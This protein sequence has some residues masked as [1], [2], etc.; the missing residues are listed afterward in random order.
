[1]ADL[2]GL[3]GAVTFYRTVEAAGLQPLVGATLTMGEAGAAVV[4]AKSLTGYRQLCRLLSAHHLDAG[5]TMYACANADMSNELIFLSRSPRLLGRLKRCLGKENLFRLPGAPAVPTLWDAGSD[6]DDIAPA[7]VP[8]AWLLHEEDREPFQWLRELRRRSGQDHGQAATWPGAV[9]PEVGEWAQHHPGAAAFSASLCERISFRFRFGEPL[10]PRVTLPPETSSSAY[11]RD[12]CEKQLQQIYRGRERQRAARRLNHELAVIQE[13]GFSD[14]FLCVHEIIAFAGQKNIPVGVRGS[15]ASSI[16]SHLLGFTH[17]CPLEHD[18]LFERFMNPG[19]RDCP[20]IDI[21]IADNRRDEVIDFCY[22]R[23]GK[24]RVAMIATVLTYRRRSAIRDAGRLLNISMERM[25]RFIREGE[26]VPGQARL[27]RIAEKLTGLPRH[28]GMHCGGLVI[29]PCPLTDVTP[30]MRSAKGV[31]I[32]QYEKDQAETIGLIKMDLLGNSAL[33]VISEAAGSL[34]ERGISFAEP[35]PA[36]DY[37]VNRLFAKGDTLGVY[38]CESPGMRQLCRALK[39]ETPKEASIA[40][41]LIRPGPAAAGMKDTFVRRRRGREPVTYL[42]P[43][44]ADFLAPTYGV[45]LYQ[46]D[47]MKVAVH[48]AGYSLADADS[49]RRAVSRKKGVR[50]MTAEQNRFVF[51]KAA[52]A[53]VSEDVSRKLW[54]QVSHFASYSYCKAHATVYG[55]LAWLTARLKAHYPREFYAAVLNCHKSMYPR[56]VFVWDAIRHGIPVLPVD[57]CAS[58]LTWTPCLKGIRA[59]LTLVKGLRRSICERLI[60]ARREAPFSGLDDLRRRVPF[61][62][63]ELQSLI[64]LGACR[65]WGTRKHLLSRLLEIEGGDRQRLLFDQVPCSLSSLLEAELALTGIPLSAHPAFFWEGQGCRAVEMPRFLNQSVWMTG[66]LDAFRRVRTEAQ[67]GRPSREMSFLTL[68]D[69]SGMF[70]V[71]L[72]PEQEARYAGKI[73]HGGPYRVWGRVRRRW[74]SLC[75]EAETIENA[76]DPASWR[77]AA[78]S[79]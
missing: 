15:A 64:F 6:V 38:Q 3:Y 68:E 26:P 39:P 55:R 77:T 33:S 44:M 14:Y 51:Q 79:A 66:I 30:L 61:R 63:G 23:W 54:E 7:P 5:D 16:V 70:E 32:S 28:V 18:L 42:H 78:S 17:C 31:V 35:G 50:G 8:D 60:A 27:L 40:L 25:N 72:F 52:E 12:L 45:M 73:R 20:D 59:P 62:A 24:E 2:N 41:S 10:L 75:L 22:R 56:R 71:V 58:G 37:K 76:R 65:A 49:L 67:E 74:D 9:L 43:R 29:T 1:M 36:Y 47:V 48:L 46:E 4:L 69:S 19:R 57:V 11:L 53:G 21:D 13:N 34:A